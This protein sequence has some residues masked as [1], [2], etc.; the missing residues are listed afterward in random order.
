MFFNFTVNGAPS[1]LEPH[2]PPLDRR[3]TQLSRLCDRYGPEAVQWRFDPIC[4]WQ[5]GNRLRHNLD[6]F[7]DIAIHAGRLGIRRCVTSFV[8]LYPKV[9]RRMTAGVCPALVDPSTELKLKTLT[10]MAACLSTWSIHLMLCCE[11]PLIDRL[12]PGSGIGAGACVPGSWL[13]S[14]IGAAAPLERDRGQRKA[15]GCGCTLSSDIGDYRR[16][17]C[18]HRCAY[19]YANPDLPDGH[20]RPRAPRLA[21]R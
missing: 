13:R 6:R 8:D 21:P 17:P 3:L 19:C 10:Q 5:D 9:R 12:P 11:K 2:L 1:R 20:D 16:H 14:R 18:P 7:S 15:A 4:F